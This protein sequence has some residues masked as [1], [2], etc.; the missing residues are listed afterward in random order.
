MEPALKRPTDDP[1]ADLDPDIAEVLMSRLDFHEDP[2]ETGAE[3]LAEADLAGEF[4]VLVVAR[5]RREMV[6][7]VRVPLARLAGID[8]SGSRAMAAASSPLSLSSLYAVRN[9]E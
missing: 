7:Q 8:V 5:R 3:E 4:E 1:L 6:L 9:P 2:E